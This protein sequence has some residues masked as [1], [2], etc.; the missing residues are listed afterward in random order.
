M[1]K[2]ILTKGHPKVKWGQIFN[3][4]P[5]CINDISNYFSQL[6]HVKNIYFYAIWALTFEIIQ[7]DWIQTMIVVEEV[8]KYRMAIIDYKKSI[9]HR[10]L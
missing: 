8:L 3:N 1:V 4:V 6:V 2:E 5:I 10:A 9:I 7:F